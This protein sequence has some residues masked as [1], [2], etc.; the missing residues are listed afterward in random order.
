MLFRS[1]TEAG[2]VYGG[3]LDV[4]S[5]VLTVDRAMVTLDGT[6]DAWIAYTFGNGKFGASYG[7]IIAE[8]YYNNVSEIISNRYHVVNR[9]AIESMDY[10]E[11]A[12]SNNKRVYFTVPTAD[13]DTLDGFK[14]W[15]ANNNVQLCYKLATPQTYQLTPTEIALLKG[16]NNVWCDTGEVEVTYKADVGLYI[17]KVLAS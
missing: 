15:L 14:A 13:I 2:T 12:L 5:G 7:G 17:D 4:V 16:Q 8:V 1:Q 11:C 6:E 3:T 10:G 9:S